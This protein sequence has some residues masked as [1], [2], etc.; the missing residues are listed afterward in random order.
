VSLLSQMEYYGKHPPPRRKSF[1]RAL[2]LFA[3]KIDAEH[4]GQGN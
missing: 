3:V 2:F 4:N 1:L